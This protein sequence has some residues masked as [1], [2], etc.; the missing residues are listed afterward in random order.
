[1]TTKL[2]PPL[3]PDAAPAA[4]KAPQEGGGLLLFR[5]PLHLQ[6]LHVTDKVVAGRKMYWH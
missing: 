3:P 6:G 1:M 5:K 4:G 2:P